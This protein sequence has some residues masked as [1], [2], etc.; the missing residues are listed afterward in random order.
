MN[1]L[2][3]CICL[4]NP[5]NKDGKKNE[6]QFIDSCVRCVYIMEPEVRIKNTLRM[7][8]GLRGHSE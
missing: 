8:G 3:H 5:M 7:C 1:F 2:I 4:Q 6:A